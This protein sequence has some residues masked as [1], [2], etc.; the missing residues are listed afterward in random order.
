MDINKNIVCYCTE[1]EKFYFTPNFVMDYDATDFANMY[2]FIGVAPDSEQGIPTEPG[3][4]S[5]P[6]YIK[7]VFKN[8]IYMKKINVND[9]SPVAERIDW[10][11]NTF[12]DSYDHTLNMSGRDENGKL[13]RKFYV[14]N[15]YD[16]VFK[17]LWNNVN[18]QNTFSI[19]SLTN[20]SSYY[21]IEHSGGTFEPGSYITIQ[22]SDPTEYNGTYVIINSS[23]GIANVAYGASG[24]YIIT[25]DKEY[26]ANASVKQ[27]S[28]S[29]EEPYFD[30]G[31]FDK[32][33]IVKP[34]DGYKWKYLYTINKASK[35][36]FFDSEWMPVPVQTNFYNPNYT[37]SGW[38][39]IDVINVINGGSGF[40]NGANTVSVLVSGD[41]IGVEAEAYVVDNKIQDIIVTNPGYDYISA[42]VS[43]I[44]VS[45]Y[46]GSGAEVVASISPNGGHG[47]NILRD[48]YTRNIMVN[49]S[50]VE[51]ENGT[52][53]TDLSFN[54]IGILYNPFVYSDIYNIANSSYIDCTTEIVLS[55]GE[56][57]F[58]YGETI[59]QG[60]SFDERNFS[61]RVVSYDPTN[62]S[63]RVINTEGTVETNFQV[64]GHS[65]GARRVVR[66]I[67]TSAFVPNSGNMFYLENKPEIDRSPLGT[68]QLRIL[69]RYS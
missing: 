32:G 2:M 34:S 39:S 44:P 33:V 43:L 47:L 35:L 66:Q 15:K 21:T 30:V 3:I 11:A 36:K 20:N 52:L 59:F 41:G 19:S 50:F 18:S 26:V 38:G 17:C 13:I 28:L 31:T 27:A 24:S 49:I 56:D 53:P 22:N 54:Q 51:G 29:I 37:V 58:T 60:A 16:Q 40:E 9:I 69:I 4:I 5:S 64:L 57:L 55:P 7:K 62:F 14:R 23:F 42:N 10:K 67:N 6:T 1:L 46:G 8:M 48:L 65:S 61:A 12:Y 25:T 63:L 45:G 68:D